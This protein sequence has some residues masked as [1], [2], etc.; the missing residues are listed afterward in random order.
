MGDL[1]PE[2]NWD[3]GEK[4]AREK[5]LIPGTKGGHLGLMCPWWVYS[6]PQGSFIST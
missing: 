2:G 4:S 1:C 6:I 3:E 5:L